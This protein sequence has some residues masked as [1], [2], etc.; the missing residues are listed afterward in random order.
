M[1]TIWNTVKICI[2]YL[3]VIPIKVW[4]LFCGIWIAQFMSDHFAISL[5]FGVKKRRFN[6][7]FEYE[8]SL[9]SPSR[10]YVNWI[11]F[12]CVHHFLFSL[13]LFRLLQ[14]LPLANACNFGVYIFSVVVCLFIPSTSILLWHAKCVCNFVSATNRMIYLSWIIKLTDKG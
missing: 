2:T 7:F 12:T 5:H 9:F 11:S 6:A 1:W 8:H 14:L 4:N 3:P 10:R 13:W